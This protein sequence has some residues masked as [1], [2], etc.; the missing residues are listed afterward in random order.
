LAGADHTG[1]TWSGTT[2]PNGVQQDPPCLP[3]LGS[4]RPKS[5]V[6]VTVRDSGDAL[7]VDLKPD[8]G[9][10]AWSFTLERLA[11]SGRWVAVGTYR[12]DGPRET[13][14]V[15]PPKGTYRVVVPPQ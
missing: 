9:G 4:A 3:L 14:T 5:S 12:T 2:C 8:L 10:D 7:L 15:N 13:R 11:A 1:A 6:A